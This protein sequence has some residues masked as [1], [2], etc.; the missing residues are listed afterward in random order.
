[1]HWIVDPE[2]GGAW[3]SME[4]VALTF[5]TNTRKAIAPSAEARERVGKLVVAGLSV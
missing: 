3:A 1:V 2:S 5:D 4:A